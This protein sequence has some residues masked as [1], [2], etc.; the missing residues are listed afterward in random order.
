MQFQELIWAIVKISWAV[1]KI[2]SWPI[3]FLGLGGEMELE[4][5]EENFPMRPARWMKLP[6]ILAVAIQLEI[7]P[8]P[9]FL[10]FILLYSNSVRAQNLIH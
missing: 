6:L 9:G 2:K 1:I 8:Q 5:T 4:Y 7:I 3:S 10:L